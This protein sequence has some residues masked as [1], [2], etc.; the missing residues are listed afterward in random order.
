MAVWKS[1]NSMLTQ[2]GVEI[3]NKIKSGAGAITVTRV[4]ASSNRVPD[5]ALYQQK[6]LGGVQKDL[7]ISKVIIAEGGSEI[8]STI[9]NTGY[10]ESFELHQI[11][12]FVTHPDYTGEQLYH[13]SQCEDEGHDLIPAEFE[14]QVSLGYS[15]FLEHGNSDSINLTVDPTG[16]VRVLDFNQHLNDATNPHKVTATQVGLGNVPNVAT[17]DQTPTYTEASS[18]SK[19]TSGE[20][21][22]VAFG[23]IAK[24]IAYLKGLSDGDYGVPNAQRLGGKYPSEYA[25]TASYNY[26]MYNDVADTDI[27]LTASTAT[28]AQVWSKLPSSSMLIVKSSYITATGWNFPVEG[29]LTV[30]KFSSSSGYAHLEAT[31]APASRY[32]MI[33]NASNKL[34]G[35]WRSMTD[36]TLVVPASLE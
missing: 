8:S 14:S 24:A 20:T 7:V 5:S 31:H 22:S 11:G 19:L 26:K 2:V 25:T 28:P 32:Y 34:D 33:L 27:A 13:I 1:E 6:V 10:T 36:N 17:N 16:M 23:K 15:I 35:V 30:F 4:V 29:I 21:L 3:L 9:T 18:F 12:I